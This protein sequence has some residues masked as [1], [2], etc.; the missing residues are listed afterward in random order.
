MLAGRLGVVV[1]RSVALM[2]VRRVLGV[3]GCG[4]TP[5]ANEVEIAVLRQ[6]LAVLRRQVA[7]PRYTPADRMLL[8]V[9]AKV[10]PR[11]R[12][13]VFLVSPSTLLRWHRELV[14][15][16]WTYPHI[17]RGARG[18]DQHVVDLVPR[19]GGPTWTQFLRAQVGGLLAC[20][21]FTVETVGLTRLYVLF[22]VEVERRR[23]HLA[24]I[25]A[26][27][28]VAWVTPQARNLLMDL[29]EQP[30][31][32][33]HLIRDRDAKFT[34]AFDAVFASAGVEVV[35]TPPRVPQANA[36]AERWVRTV[37]SDCLDWTLI[38][39]ERQLHRVL[40]EYLAH[41]NSVRPHRALDLQPPA[42][43]RTLTAVGAATAP[44]TVDVERVDVLGGL[45]HEYRRAAR[46]NELHSPLPGSATADPAAQR[47]RLPAA[48]ESRGA[49]TDRSPGRRNF[50]TAAI[51]PPSGTLHRAQRTGAPRR[52]RH[53]TPQT[54]TKRIDGHR[55]LEQPSGN[56]SSATVRLR[57][58]CLA[59]PRCQARRRVA[60]LPRRRRLRATEH[61][62]YQRSGRIGS[63]PATRPGPMGGPPAWRPGRSGLL[64]GEHDPQ[65]L[66][67]S[68][69]PRADDR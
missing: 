52:E 18:L 8:A 7:R 42:A 61:R 11:E 3:L 15:R 41:Y 67:L 69:S 65:G 35:Q 12:W 30:H 33:R 40:T 6:Q 64:R 20:D 22:V 36:F 25:T 57:S 4:P 2:I 21:F 46:D 54:L 9:L 28:T 14:A 19:R 43:V 60:T 53:Q 1:V 58:T 62:I 45:I 59:T 39:S 68:A 37:R 47:W 48:S 26:H 55:D 49:S 34:A 17:G 16:R 23:V 63:M 10:L 31:R 5:D 44:T 24:G 29:D 51:G 13:P 50:A 56:S 27:P 32:F 66:R 38:W